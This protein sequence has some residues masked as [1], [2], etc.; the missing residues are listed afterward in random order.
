MKAKHASEAKRFQDIP[1]V[2]PRMEEDFLQLGFKNPSDLKGQDA[3]ALYQEMCRLTGTRHDPCVLD[4]YMAVIDF[5][6]GA[7]AR[8]W[9]AYTA[10][11]RRQHPEV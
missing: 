8:P 2:G 7:S 3:L 11:R 6:N 10:E 9:H 4:T 1:N 5:M